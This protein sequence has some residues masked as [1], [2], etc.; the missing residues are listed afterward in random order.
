MLEYLNLELY[1][2]NIELIRSLGTG[3]AFPGSPRARWRTEL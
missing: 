3:S 2:E 1:K